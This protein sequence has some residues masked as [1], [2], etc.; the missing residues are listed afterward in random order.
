MIEDLALIAETLITRDDELLRVDSYNWK[1]MKQLP[2]YKKIK[3]A[4]ELQE[5][6]KEYEHEIEIF[7]DS[8]GR[9]VTNELREFM[10][11]LHTK[12]FQ[13][14]VSRENERK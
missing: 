14:K 5:L 10:D 7:T 9:M 13:P 1:P 8:N 4:A 2:E 11:K 3:S 6:I 12:H